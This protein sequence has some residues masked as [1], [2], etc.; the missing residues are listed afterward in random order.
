MDKI[1]HLENKYSIARYD[2]IQEC[3][4]DEMRF[5]LYLKLYAIN[6]HEAFPTYSTISKDLSW[7]RKK[8]SRIIK[9]MVKKDRLKVGKILRKIKGIKQAVNIYDITWYDHVNNQGKIKGKVEVGSGK[10]E[11]PIKGEGSGKSLLKPLAINKQLETM[12]DKSTS[13]VLE[14]ELEKLLTDHK[15]YIQIIGVWIKEMNFRPE[16]K[17]QM[18]SIIKRFLRPAKLLEGYNND[19]I[20][21]TIRVL[22]NTQYITKFTPETI[23]KYIDEVVANKKKEGAKILRFEKVEKLDGSIAMRPIYVKT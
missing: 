23:S 15:R 19:D 5:Y 8:I 10:L 7:D 22:R 9:L 1:K 14:E 20:I 21:E 17:D 11:L 12:S 6:K 18:Q 3:G 4:G 16:N 2:L 13:W